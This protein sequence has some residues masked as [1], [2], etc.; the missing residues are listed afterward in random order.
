MIGSRH[1][2]AMIKKGNSLLHRE[3]EL[4]M[5]VLAF[6]GSETMSSAMAGIF[7]QLLRAPAA[8]RKLEGEIRSAFA[9]EGEITF[10]SVGKFEYLTAVIQEGIRFGTPAAISLPH[11]VP[12]G[13]AMISGQWVPAGTFVSV[14]QYP[15]YRSPAN[16]K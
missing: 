5:T 6:A 9:D 13:G 15:A 7:T 10:S 12:Q 14:N 1:S 3:L 11:V 2:L 16:F 4:N 8:L